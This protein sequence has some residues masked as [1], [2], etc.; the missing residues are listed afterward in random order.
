MGLQ[1]IPRS[2]TTLVWEHCIINLRTPNLQ[3][4]CNCILR[5]K[6]TYNWQ[7]DTIMSCKEKI[8]LEVEKNFGTWV[9]S[10]IY[11]D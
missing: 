9:N 5:T 10:C 11:R 4:L 2:T 3:H 1:R 7:V 6:K 8:T